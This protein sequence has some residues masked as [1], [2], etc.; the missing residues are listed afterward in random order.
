MWRNKTESG[1]FLA[2]LE[3]VNTLKENIDYYTTKL[4]PGRM[5]YVEANALFGKTVGMKIVSGSDSV[6]VMKNGYLTF[7]SSAFSDAT[8]QAESVKWFSDIMKEKEI[9]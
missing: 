4:L 7:E 8:K 3:K 2:Y 9:D 1:I 5:K 6:I